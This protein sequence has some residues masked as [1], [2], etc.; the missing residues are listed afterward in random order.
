MIK[1][2]V[3]YIDDAGDK[4]DFTVDAYSLKEAMQ[5]VTNFCPDCVR[6]IS[7]TPQSTADK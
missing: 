3:L 2:D 6:I 5:D 4:Q 7:C 1:F